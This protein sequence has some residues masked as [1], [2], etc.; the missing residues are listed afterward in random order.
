MPSRT[1]ITGPPSRRFAITRI[2]VE[3]VIVHAHDEKDARLT[4]EWCF[5]I[6]QEF[7]EPSGA[8]CT[9]EP[10]PAILAVTELFSC[11]RCR[12]EDVSESFDFFTQIVCRD[13]VTRNL[14]LCR[15]TDNC[16][17]RY[18]NSGLCACPKENK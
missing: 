1:A 4:S 9:T 7:T 6:V 11:D 3:T 13:R 16:M 5:P 2:R 18:H 12:R 15:N 17:Q 8:Q 14:R 10:E